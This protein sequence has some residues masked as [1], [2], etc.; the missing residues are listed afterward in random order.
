MPLL[1][2]VCYG[3]D[4]VNFAHIPQLYRLEPT[5]YQKVLQAQCRITF[6]HPFWGRNCSASLKTRPRNTKNSNCPIFG[7]TFTN[8]L[9]EWLMKWSSI[10]FFTALLFPWV[11]NTSKFNFSNGCDWKC[12]TSVLRCNFRTSVESFSKWMKLL[13]RLINV[14]YFH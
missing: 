8:K 12:R 11:S 7:F 1:C 10:S 6:Y 14:V 2:A 4:N 3:L 9:T 5:L 13:F